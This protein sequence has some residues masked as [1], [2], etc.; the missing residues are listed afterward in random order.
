MCAPFLKN[1]KSRLATRIAIDE[2][3]AAM[4]LQER[5]ASVSGLVV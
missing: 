2:R 5:P 3:D 4:R 1:E